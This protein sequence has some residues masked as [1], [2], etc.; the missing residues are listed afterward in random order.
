METL[1]SRLKFLR[2]DKK[3]TQQQLADEVGVSKTS[4]IYWEKDENIPKHESLI[5]LSKVL[6]TSI[7][8]N[9]WIN[10][11]CLREMNLLSM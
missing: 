8:K 5:L 10:M 3:M 9:L 4:V 1:G 2:K 11:A 6:I 7:C